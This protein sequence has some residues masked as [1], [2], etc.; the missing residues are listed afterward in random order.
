M[1]G[2]ATLTLAK[3]EATL[4]TNDYHNIC[5]SYQSWTH[6][7]QPTGSS[8]FFLCLYFMASGKRK[9]DEKEV[10]NYCRQI[11]TD[12]AVCNH[13]DLRVCKKDRFWCSKK[14]CDWK[15]CRA[16]QGS[17]PWSIRHVTGRQWLCDEHYYE[18]CCV[19]GKDDDLYECVYCP[20]RFC[21]EHAVWCR[22]EDCDHTVCGVCQQKPRFALKFTCR[23][24]LCRA[25]AEGAADRN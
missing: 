6:R 13:C 22:A 12:I 16:C 17:K 3:Q 20:R 9:R 1:S 7:T 25:H 18:V 10:C 11:Q 5:H 24:W 2:W 4:P 23:G 8:S 19:C 15:V 21:D 14:E